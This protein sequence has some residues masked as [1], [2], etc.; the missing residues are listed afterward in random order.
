M[1]KLIASLLFVPC[2]ANAEFMDGNTLLSKMNDSDVIPRAV[3]LG[4]VQGVIDV[5][6]RTKVCPPQNI[7]AGQARDVVKSYLEANPGIRHK[8]ADLLV[9]DALK[10]VW[11]C[12]NRNKGNGTRL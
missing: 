4:Y 9:T 8:T 5:F 1:K 12:A 11:P 2:M 10:Q 3:S 7:T 6:V